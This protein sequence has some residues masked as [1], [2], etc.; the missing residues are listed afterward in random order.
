MSELERLLRPHV[1]RVVP[2]VTARSQYR[3]GLL[4]DANENSAGPSAPDLPSDLNR[5]PDPA[6]ADLRSAVSGWLGVAERR[7]WFGNGSDEVIDLLIRVLV[8]PGS[9]LVVSEPSYDLYAQ[10]AAAN[11]ATVRSVRLD[12]DFDLDVDG[13]LEATEGASL[14]ILCSPNNPTGN[15]LS[16]DR[17]LELLSRSKCVVAVDEAYVEF[18]GSNGRAESLA[19]LA[20]GAGANP[21]SERLA[22]L[23]TFS[24]AWGLAGARVGY[25]IG[26]PTLVEAMNCMGLPYPLSS[27]SSRAACTVLQA[28]SEMEKACDVVAAE[29]ARVA[30]SLSDLG[31]RP[32]PSDANFL[33][34]FVEHP[35]EIQERMARDYAVVIRDRSHMPG[36]DGGLRVTIGTSPDNDRVLEVLREVLS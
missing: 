19:R 28:A 5:Y 13:T 30:R 25:V 32:L 21:G 11:G 31:L 18:A 12:G 36:L 34:F 27:L 16:A 20:G 15:L 10:R 8:D 9:P 22:V 29:R 24:K 4:L 3:G 17:I 23:R 6:N 14:V 7:L 33:L 1:S 26:A 2:Y 35:L